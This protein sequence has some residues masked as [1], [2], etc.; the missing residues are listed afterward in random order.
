MPV[1]LETWVTPSLAALP[2]VPY[3]GP[4]TGMFLAISYLS[5]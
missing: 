3:E 1:V 2:A 5:R 4:S